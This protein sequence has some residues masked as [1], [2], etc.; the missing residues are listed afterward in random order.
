MKKAIFVFVA[1]FGSLVLACPSMAADA[2]TP[3]ATV[4]SFS[5]IVSVGTAEAEKMSPV[6]AGMNLM[7]DNIIE[8]GAQSQIVIR[9]SAEEMMVTV[10][11]NTKIALQDLLLKARLEKMRGSIDQPGEDV[12]KTDL[13]VTPLTGVRGTE[14]AEDKSKEPKREHHWEDNAQQ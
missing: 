6:Q 8:T 9:F 12:K 2:A 1:L 3:L 5:G 7:E 10:G 14:K 11:E 13:Q 4:D